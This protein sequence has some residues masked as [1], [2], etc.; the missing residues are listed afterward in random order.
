M[1]A[2]LHLPERVI[3]VAGLCLGLPSERGH[4]SPRLGLDATVHHDRYSER[5]AAADID[6][7]DRRRNQNRPQ[8][9][10]E[11]CCHDLLCEYAFMPQDV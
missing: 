5:D 10:R 6:A 7:Y 3:P 11:G 1:S 2:L 4:I 9:I 8:S